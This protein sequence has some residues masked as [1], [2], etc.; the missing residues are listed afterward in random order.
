MGNQQ[1]SQNQTF[2]KEKKTESV[3][4][5]LYYF[6]GRGRA[7]QVTLFSFILFFICFI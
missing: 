7:D 1:T 6:A 4:A 2:E 3:D 5:T